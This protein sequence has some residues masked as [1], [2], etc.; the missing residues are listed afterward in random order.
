MSKKSFAK[1][2]LFNL[3]YQIMAIALPLITTPYLS[4]VLGADSIGRYSFAQSIVSYFALLAAL[5]TTMYGQ[6]LIARASKEP[7]ERSRLF[8]EIFL[9]RGIGAIVACGIYCLTIMPSASDPL[10]YTVAA[11]EIA[12]VAIDITWFYQGME[13]FRPVAA[14]T[15]LG[16]LLAIV[17]I[18][19]FVKSREDLVVYVVL[20]C[21]SILFGNLLTWLDLRHYLVGLG[22]GERKLS[23]LSH[24][25]PALSL[26]VSQVAIQV[27][28]VLDKTMI[29]LIT[30][31]DFENGYYEQGQKL[32]RVLVAL[33]TSM[34]VVMASRVAV[35]WKEKK[36]EQVYRLIES[37]FRL[38][39][40]L[41]IPI[42]LGITLVASRFVPV[43]YGEGFEPV[44]P[45]LIVLSAM[46]PVIGCSNVIGIQLLVPSGREKLLTVSVSVGAVVNVL[47]NLGLIYFFASVGAAVASLL[48]EIVV[49]SVQFFFVRK[50]I[51]I[52]RILKIALRYLL[53]GLLMAALGFVISLFAPGGILGIALIVLPC[54]AVYGGLLVATKD[55]VFAM[56]KR[57]KED[58]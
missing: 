46:I 38:V 49:T 30:K 54:I 51:R 12:A 42:A 6:R 29:G 48:A 36:K 17:G 50:E 47:L 40:A 39:F 58:A 56:F 34:G 28:V 24:F 19:L 37:S 18:F 11:I 10:L 57:N 55:P 2:Y 33:V 44:I 25:L 21:G 3:I 43:F 15:A 4:R 7:K 13:D 16:K 9:F 8:W 45:L 35:L 23:L 1:N 14:Y 41:S 26:F 31:S 5:G 22:R 52:G 20:Y 53:F 27:Y 32:S